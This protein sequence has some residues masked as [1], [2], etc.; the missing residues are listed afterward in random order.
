M[1][2]HHQCLFLVI[3]PSLKAWI[4]SFVAFIG[5]IC[6]YPF[7]HLCIVEDGYVK[8]VRFLELSYAVWIIVYDV[9]SFDLHPRNTSVNGLDLS[10]A[11]STVQL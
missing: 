9:E 4:H 11:G 10:F 6:S 2:L 5:N 1:T 8:P 7:T 3:P